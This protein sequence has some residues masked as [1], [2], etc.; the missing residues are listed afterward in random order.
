MMKDLKNKAFK[1]HLYLEHLDIALDLARILGP[2]KTSNI[3]FNKE[4]RF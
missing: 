1:H 4:L 3:T 2:E